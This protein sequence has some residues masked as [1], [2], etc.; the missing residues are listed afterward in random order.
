MACDELCEDESAWQ[1]AI[2]DYPNGKMWENWDLALDAA[3]RP[4]VALYEPPSIDITARGALYFAWCDNNCTTES[5][6]KRTPIATGEGRSVDLGIDPQGRMHMV[7]DGG[8]RGVLSAAWCANNCGQAGQWHREVLET[9][10]QLQNEFPV[11]SPFTCDQQ[12]RG[13]LDALPTLAFDAQGRRI[14][15]YD[16]KNVAVCY[17]TDPTNPS[18]PPTTR[19]ERLWWAVRW[20]FFP[21]P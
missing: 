10:D 2:L 6:W 20:A 1:Q 13:W 14:V 18:K 3:G 12:K 7:Y 16:L 21:K 19:V 5:S 8:Q 11:A 9:G 17:Y 4:R 15:A